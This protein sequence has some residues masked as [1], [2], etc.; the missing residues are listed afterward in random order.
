MTYDEAMRRYGIDR[1]DL[2]FGC[3]LVDFTDYFADTR[4]G[5]SSRP[6]GGPTTSTS[7]PS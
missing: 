6:D 7:A 2:R 3:E 4:S 1:P 5:S